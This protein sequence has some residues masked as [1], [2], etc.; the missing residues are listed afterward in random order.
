MTVVLASAGGVWHYLRM[1]AMTFEEAKRDLDTAVNQ[2]LHGEEVIITVGDQALR[3]IRDIPFRPPGY[4][5]ACYADPAD[6][7]FEE[8]VCRDSRPVLES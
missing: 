7:A 1:T 6:A 3:L 8:R 2:A 5:T 4:F